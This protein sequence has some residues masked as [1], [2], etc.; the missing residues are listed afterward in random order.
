MT[1]SEISIRKPVFA[2]MLMFAILFFGLL[3]FKELGINENPDVDYP[4]VTINYA[5]DGATPAVIEKDVLEPVESILVSMEGI[6]MLTS[7]ADRGNG[8]IDLEFDLNK[9]IDFAL[10]E[11]QTLLGR[12]QRQLPSSVEP[13]IVTKSNA[14]DD[15]ILFLS[16][17]SE[18]LSKRELMIL[19]R[20]RV[21]DRLSTIDGIAE[22]RAF[23]YHEPI[24]RID[25]KFD[26]L[27]KYQLTA[28]D[29]LRSIEQE[30]LELP[31]G[32][33]EYGDKEEQIRVLGE[34]EKTQDFKNMVISRRGGGPNYVP[35]QLKDVA[36]VNEGIENLRRIS[37]FNSQFALGMAVQKQRGVNAV[38]TADRVIEKIEDINKGLPEGVK[39]EVNFNRTLFIKESVR[40]LVFNLVLSAILT[41]LVCWFF[42][43][44]LSAT[45]N[46][47]LAIPTSV[48]GT[49]AFMH[50]FSFTL[51]TFSLLGL[52]LAIGIVVDDAIVMLENIVRFRA[53]NFDKVKAA[54]LGSKEITFAVIATT[55]AL[56]AIFSPITLMEG[57]EGR[58][59]F[60]FAITLCIAVGISSFEALTLTPM[61][62]SQYLS[63]SA[64]GIFVHRWVDKFVS[65]TSGWY[66][67][68]LEKA[69]LYKYS[70]VAFSI[71]VFLTSLLIVRFV[72]KEF[73]P[74]VDNNVL[75]LVFNAPEGKSLEYTNEK[76]RQFE[77]IAQKHS[78]V[79]RTFVAVG[80]FG[81]GGQGN[82]GN[83]VV[84]LKNREDRK[85]SQFLIAKELREE[86]KSIT[87]IKIFIRDRS[88][89]SIGGRRGSPVEFSIKGPD[90][91]IQKQIYEKMSAEMEKSGLMVGVRSDDVLTLPEVQIVPNREEARARGV[92][93]AEIS[94]VINVA[95][96][97]VVAGQYTQGGRRFNIQVQLQELDRLNSKS[98]EN[99][100]VRNNRGELIELKNL[101]SFESE[102]S[103]QNIYRESR[104]RAIRIDANLS[105]NVV[106]GDAIKAVKEIAKTTVPEGY[107]IEFS[108]DLDD[109]LFNI[110]F[111][112]ILGLIMSYM[113]LSSQFNS[114]ADPLLV[115]LA[116]PFGISGSFLA[117]YL[118]GVT[119][120][121]YSM[122]GI[123]LT[124]G[125]VKKNS[126]LIVEFTN[127]LRDEGLSVMEALSTACRL[128]YRPIV[129]TTFATLA[130]AVPAAL[131][132]GA[133]SETRIP[134]AVVVL[135]G[136]SMST[137]FTLVVIPVFYS[138]F[139]RKRRDLD[140]QVDDILKTHRETD[141]G[142]I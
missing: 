3:G 1:L 141:P 123:L 73:A 55:L 106:V 94:R 91:E 62:C 120:N 127:Q 114:Y 96:G 58:F 95:T 79:L 88:N 29:I 138:L 27:Q 125:I 44:S 112:M 7:S 100:L 35:L 26:Q 24:M 66:K 104:E 87:G 124:M 60:E 53:K 121:V 78:D 48:I 34:A 57:I 101:V 39:L 133:G 68:A 117:L 32:R 129:M 12:A 82:K 6:R 137:V 20:D 28:T 90:P 69:M 10:Q 18:K 102:N 65:V 109:S 71:I 40:E 5:Y 54:L 43:S 135:G 38:A 14:A 118:A 47:V 92:E 23:G 67:K 45:F 70:V 52:S 126:I 8:R 17:V 113:V 64:K 59:F 25:M 107:Y 21:R 105:E 97:G 56:I 22:I 83:G 86:S 51:N 130:A 134:M 19:F 50:Y 37:R 77:S 63:V 46:I 103:P 4:T 72:P 108:Q 131:S 33:F 116:I 13:P 122:I 75:F 136:V 41:S 11:V 119:L 84:I 80:G 76:I 31:A 115:F 140:K 93:V 74:A 81:R 98:I 9:D 30:H 49:F 61:R 85:K 16:L 15:P 89:S 142:F 128:R 110:I 132:T 99:L 111:I 2:W 139:P 36:D 42:L